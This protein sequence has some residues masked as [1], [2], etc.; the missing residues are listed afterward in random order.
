MII[1]IKNTKLV[2]F[3]SILTHFSFSQSCII[4]Q[5]WLAYL[6]NNK[7]AEV[8]WLII[9]IDPRFKAVS[10]YLTF[11]KNK[12]LISFHNYMGHYFII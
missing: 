5:K 8:H 10:Y 1:K 11:Y 9:T 4:N 3:D 2:F 12:F 6:M 7:F